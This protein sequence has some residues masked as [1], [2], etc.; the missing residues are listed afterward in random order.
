MF[1][2]IVKL[3]K[4]HRAKCKKNAFDIVRYINVI[5]EGITVS[6]F[7]TQKRD[8]HDLKGIFSYI[9]TIIAIIKMLNET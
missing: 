2:N 9:S 3:L 4:P 5:P 8:K 6:N 1:T 7:C